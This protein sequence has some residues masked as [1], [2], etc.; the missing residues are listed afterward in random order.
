MEQ[1]HRAS[2]SLA[3]TKLSLTTPGKT[4][5]TMPPVAYLGSSNPPSTDLDKP[6]VPAK[7]LPDKVIEGWRDRESRD[8]SQRDSAGGVLDSSSTVSKGGV[9]PKTKGALEDQDCK[10]SS[11]LTLVCIKSAGWGGVGEADRVE[12]GAGSL[13]GRCAE[14]A[15]WE[16]RAEAENTPH[17]TEGSSKRVERAGLGSRR[18]G[19][20]EEDGVK[21][22]LGS[23]LD[24]SCVGCKRT[25]RNK[26]ES[27]ADTGSELE[28]L[29]LVEGGGASVGSS[30][31]LG[32]R[33]P[34]PYPWINADGEVSAA[35]AWGTVIYHKPSA[36]LGGVRVPPS[37]ESSGRTPSV[38]A[39]VYEGVEL[40]GGRWGVS[41]EVGGA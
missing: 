2:S 33:S 1:L 17:S 5:S 25:P 26:T 3:N 16:S 10:L 9:A 15:C 37:E 20:E 40:S 38:S 19:A 23:P 30:V 24:G 18:G 11:V 6:A 14:A 27:G 36:E 35:P 12:G 22:E 39:S 13:L 29:V 21:T 8:T 7:A 31:A 4:D 32:D 34:S 28:V 41:S